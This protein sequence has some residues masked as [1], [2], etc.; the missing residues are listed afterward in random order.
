MRQKTDEGY[1]YGVHEVYYDKD[2]KPEKHSKNPDPVVGEDMDVLRDIIEKFKRA[3]EK[4]VL[5]WHE[6][7]GY[8]EVTDLMKRLWG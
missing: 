2:D 4:P 6:G 8:L 1:W 3:L 7:E 5:E